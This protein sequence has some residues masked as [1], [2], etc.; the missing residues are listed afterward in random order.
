MIN[1]FMSRGTT[2]E[3]NLLESLIIESIQAWGIDFYY[4]PRTLVSPDGILREDRLSKFQNAYKIEMYL[5]TPEG[6]E[7][8]G[9]FIDNL[10]FGMDF[11]TT[12]TVSRKR[13]EELVASD[14]KSILQNRPAEGDLIYFPITKSLFEIKFV[15]HQ[16]PFY[17]LGRL[18]SYKLQIATFDYSSE[19]IETGIE[20]IDDFES[21]RTYSI[22]PTETNFG[23]VTAIEMSNYGENYTHAEVTITGD[24]TGAAALA[25]VSGGRVASISIYDAGEGYSE[26]PTVTITGDGTG[27]VATA[28]ISTNI[29]KQSRTGN[30]NS[31]DDF[32]DEIIASSNN[33][34][35]SI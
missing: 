4:I 29:D 25:E 1:P 32:A 16:D 33:D 31:F 26:A 2:S 23:E 10:G 13:W 7:S 3:E 21:L 27:A 19:D 14:E 15:E 17:Q 5:E 28:T 12:L 8:Q 11:S 22:D 6:F 18:Y 9:A 20:D 24:G 34:Y 30:N 35:G